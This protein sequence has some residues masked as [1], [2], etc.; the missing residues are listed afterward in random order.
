MSPKLPVGTEKETCAARGA[1][2]QWGGRMGAVGW[3]ETDTCAARGAWAQ[4]GGRMGA[5]GRA[6]G[7]SGAGDWA[8]WEVAGA[9]RR[10]G[11]GTVRGE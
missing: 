10:A 8:Q 5:V 3:G 6:H 7:R 2:A 11:T 1:W 4:W 9:A